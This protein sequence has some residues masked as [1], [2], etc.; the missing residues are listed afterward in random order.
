MKKGM[1]IAFEGI[2]GTGK[3]SQLQYLANYLRRKGKE[4]VETREPTDGPYG[5]KIRALYTS[6]H[7]VTM[8]EELDLFIADRRQH[9]AECIQPALD[10]GCVVLTDRYYYS[11][12]AYQGALGADP[13]SIFQRNAFAPRPDLVLLLTMGV[14]V[15]LRRIQEQR[16]EQLN[17]FEQAAQ[18]EQVAA[19]FASFDDPAIVRIEAGG[20][21]AEVQQKIRETVDRVCAQKLQS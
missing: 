8:E 4:V 2:D 15:S 21:F 7:T 17:D 3:T 6:R 5:Q 12:A 9:V 10:K 16:Q 13:K 19:L 20:A 1:L 14:D 11:T 18:L